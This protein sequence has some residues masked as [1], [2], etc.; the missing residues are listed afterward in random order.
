MYDDTDYD[1]LFHDLEDEL[2][3]LMRQ[4][5]LAIRF[6]DRP[7]ERMEV[8]AIGKRA[9]RLLHF[10]LDLRIGISSNQWIWLGL[11]KNFRVKRLASHELEVVGRIVCHFPFDDRFVLRYGVWSE[12]V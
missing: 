11:E 3:A 12:P 5:E 2:A 4:Y 10:H 1:G 6:D 9:R 8:I 7:A